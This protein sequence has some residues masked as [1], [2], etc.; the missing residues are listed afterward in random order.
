MNWSWILILAAIVGFAIALILAVGFGAHGSPD[1][2][3]IPAAGLCGFL[4]VALGMRH[5]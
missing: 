4:G 2:W 3:L 1:K 5:G